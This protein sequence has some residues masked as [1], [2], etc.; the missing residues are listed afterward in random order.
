[1]RITNRF[2]R[3]FSP[4][5]LLIVLALACSLPGQGTPT[6]L[7]A[8]PVSV[9]SPSP[10]LTPTLLP[11]LPPALIETNPPVGSDVPL[12]GPLTFYFNQPM[13]RLSVEGALMGQ[14]GLAGRFTWQDDS[15]LL[16][17]PDTPFPPDA[18]LALTLNSTARAA[19]GLALPE[20]VTISYQTA[21]YLRLSE[22]LP[23]PD[24][25]LVDPTAAVV[26]AFNQPVVS[27]GAGPVADP[28]AFTLTPLTPGQG[29]WLNT[30]TYIF[31][32][33]PA[34]FGGSRY[35]V[36]LNPDLVSVS[37]GPLAPEADQTLPGSWSFTTASPRLL[38]IEPDP[39]MGDLQ[40]DAEFHLAF[41]Q[42]MDPDSVGEHLGLFDPLG[43]PVSGDLV[44]DGDNSEATLI[45]DR[46]LARNSE[47]V[48]QLG[49]EAQAAGGTAIGD[50]LTVVYQ[51]V[52]G[53]D[54]LSTE[55]AEGGTQSPQGGVQIRFNGPL[56]EDL[57]TE[58]LALSPAVPELSTYWDV[59]TAT[60]YVNGFYQP[61]TDYTLILSPGLADPW[62][63]I[64]GKPYQLDFRTG[65]LPP[66]LTVALGSNALFLTPEDSALT[67]QATNLPE[68]QV[69]VGTVPLDLFIR[70]LGPGGYQLFEILP[71]G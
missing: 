22:A 53:L 47:Y 40:L 62:G 34:L 19:N 66:D 17:A 11:P 39:E 4:L 38:T 18:A 9:M 33:A 12:A 71:A 51:T 60:L 67:V 42:P 15:T 3:S 57:I 35:T 36:T 50:T 48:L 13:D 56:D 59:G 43:A 26:A 30:S 58:N 52:P 31:Y 68:I 46:L 70:L 16:F 27:L 25:E 61:E 6:P 5:L 65:S 10:A 63:G 41:N 32:P 2:S 69:S 54:I 21:G 1:M 7:A 49:P 64:L 37:G 29:E 20:P 28:P 45:P 24:S 23:R 8:S 44:W 55:P 14:P